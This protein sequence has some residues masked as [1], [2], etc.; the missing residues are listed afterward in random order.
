MK[1]TDSILKDNSE[2]SYLP[3]RCLVWLVGVL[4]AIGIVLSLLK[5]SN[6]NEI[7]ENTDKTKIN[8][9]EKSI[10]PKYSEPNSHLAR[11]IGLD[12]DI[13]EKEKNKNTI[14]HFTEDKKHREMKFPYYFL[15]V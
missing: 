6:Q 7:F 1:L 9:V 5:W 3:M 11:K 14:N 13:I 4:C 12:I 8:P 15:K 2:L 10:K